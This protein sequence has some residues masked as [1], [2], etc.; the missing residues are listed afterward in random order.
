MQVKLKHAKRCILMKVHLA[1]SQYQDKGI[2][3]ESLQCRCILALV[4]MWQLCGV[5]AHCSCG[6]FK[7][8]QSISETAG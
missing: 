8:G 5:S 2:W 6:L 1:S 3:S 7:I 4:V